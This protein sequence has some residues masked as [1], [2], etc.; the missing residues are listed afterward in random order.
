M[1]TLMWLYFL[2]VTIH[3]I[4]GAPGVVD[5]E[6]ANSERGIEG[7]SDKV[8]VNLSPLVTVVKN[9]RAT[10]SSTFSNSTEFIEA[11]KT[12]LKQVFHQINEKGIF[13]KQL[14]SME[15][16]V[17][18]FV[19]NAKNISNGDVFSKMDKFLNG[20]ETK[21]K[22]AESQLDWFIGDVNVNL[23]KITTAFGDFSNGLGNIWDAFML[24]VGKIFRNNKKEN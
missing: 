5:N 23:N 6:V 18:N 2:C 15:D 8:Q 22:T 11:I 3:S 10:L 14:K 1:S 17:L 4:T 12:N 24:G 13:P 7:N 9:F 21:L 16:G 20:L 19:E